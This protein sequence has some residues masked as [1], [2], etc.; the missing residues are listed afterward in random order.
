VLAIAKVKSEKHRLFGDTVPTRALEAFFE[1]AVSEAYGSD[2]KPEH[3]AEPETAA[4]EA[5]HTEEP[6]ETVALLRAAG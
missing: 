2:A 1:R 4:A 5:R 3:A 6:A